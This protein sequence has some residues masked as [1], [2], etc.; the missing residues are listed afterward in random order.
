MLGC[1]KYTTTIW[2]PIKDS[3]KARSN[4]IVVCLDLAN[5]YGPIP[6]PLI[7]KALKAF[8]VNQDIITMLQQSFGGFKMCFTT[9]D[10]ITSWINLGIGIAMGC[11]ISP[12]LFVMARELILDALYSW[13]ENTTNE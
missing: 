12:T 10:Y 7:L 4:V 11:S 5:A 13:T 3:R 8:H 9:E 2:D 1:I 6:H